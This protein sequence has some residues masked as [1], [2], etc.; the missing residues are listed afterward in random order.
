MRR[1]D[2][3]D[4]NVR[5]RLLAAAQGP[6]AFACRQP[7]LARLAAPLVCWARAL[8]G[9]GAGGPAIN[10]TSAGSVRKGLRSNVRER[11]CA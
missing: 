9:G 4:Q 7:I 3:T 1:V 8:P 2:G 5:A 10:I 11:Q 6:T